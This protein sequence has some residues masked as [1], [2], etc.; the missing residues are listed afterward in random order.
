MKNQGIK[1]LTFTNR[2]IKIFLQKK[3]LFESFI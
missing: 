3:D 2:D 1:T